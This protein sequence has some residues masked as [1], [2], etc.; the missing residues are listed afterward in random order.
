MMV[1]IGILIG[2]V[3]VALGWLGRA[4]FMKNLIA[5]AY[6]LGYSHAIMGYIEL[7]E[8]LPLATR[9]K[10]GLFFKDEVPCNE[11]KSLPS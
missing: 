6:L 2:L 8:K 5:E 3:G 4:M 1:F 9:S 10:F 11:K 7:L